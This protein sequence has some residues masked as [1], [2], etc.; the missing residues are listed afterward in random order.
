[1]EVIEKVELIKNIQEKA[2]IEHI[3]AI[4]VQLMEDIQL[5]KRI[6]ILE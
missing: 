6:E 1:M 4:M 3:E 5:V 2:L